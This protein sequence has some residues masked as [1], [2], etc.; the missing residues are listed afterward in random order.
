MMG[1]FFPGFSIPGLKEKA[2][3]PNIESLVSGAQ[4]IVAGWLASNSDLVNRAC[5]YT[6]YA[7]GY[8]IP[9]DPHGDLR[10]AAKKEFQ[11]GK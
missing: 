9:T 4:D 8:R 6:L 3:A 11:D 7:Q 10:R 5:Y 2:D 1:G